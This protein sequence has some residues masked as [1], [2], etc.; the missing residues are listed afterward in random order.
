VQSL[1]SVQERGHIYVGTLGSNERK[2]IVLAN[3]AAV[4]SPTGHL[5]YCRDRTL[6]SQA[7]DVKRLEL[8]GEPTVIAD[9]IYNVFIG[10]G[11]AAFSV[12][13]NGVMAYFKGSS[14][15][16]QFAWK[17]RTGKTVEILGTPGEYQRPQLSHDGRHFAY[18]IAD[19][20]GNSDIW[21][22][23]GARQTSTRFTFGPG[24]NSN[25][26][27][28]ADDRYL[29]YSSEQLDRGTREIVRKAANGVGSPETVFRSTAPVLAI[30]D[31]SPD[32]RYI[33]FHL[34]EARTKTGLDVGYYS[35]AEAKSGLV[36]QTPSFDCCGRLSPDGKWLSYTSALS[37]RNEIYV[38]PFPAVTGRFQIS[39]TGGTQARWSANG[40]ELFYVS[41]DSKVM[42]V[43]IQA[44]A[45]F[46]AGLP[47]PL[48]SIHAKP[49]GWPF[50]VS[51]DGRFLVNERVHTE[52][53]APVTVVLNWS[54]QLDR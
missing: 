54:A 8:H 44:G 36:V 33:V 4:Y 46:E 38:Q 28:S 41:P 20:Q 2:L 15:L 47:K 10:G 21:I 51:R 13:Q 7:F 25:A 42:A 12:S 35:I 6:V 23:D 39:T 29:V 43:E 9:N 50:D 40:K 3:S 11:V 31:S 37:G 52:G 48:F 34:I 32:G 22:Y 5:L 27:W 1:G 14:L 19:P 24:S 17:D 16:S 53:G 18:E 49:G 30:T 45:T 26:V